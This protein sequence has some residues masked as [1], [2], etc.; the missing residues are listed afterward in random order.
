VRKIYYVIFFLFLTSN[1]FASIEEN[2]LK[3]FKNIENISFNFEQNINGKIENGN[4]TIEYPKKIYCKY[5]LGNKKVLVSNGKS[6]VIKTLTSYYI[7]PLER[8]PLYFILNKNYLLK[9]IKDIKG[10]DINNNFINYRFIENDNEINLFFDKKT[11]NL[12]G[13][14]TV[15]IYQNI[16]I[17]YLS[18]IKRNQKLDN[19]LFILPQQ[20]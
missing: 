8:T 5:N 20:N 18:F 15:D 4:C 2:I 19:E 7:Y 1:V 13:W 12:I 17:T 9:K 16:S 14:Q 3:K 6:L 11:Y 10:R